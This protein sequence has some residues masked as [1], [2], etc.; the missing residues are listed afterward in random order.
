MIY[1]AW[2][3]YRQD[4]NEFFTYPPEIHRAIYTADAIE[5]LN[6][7]IK[8]GAKDRS[9]IVNDE[10]VYKIRYSAVRNSREKR[11]VLIK[12]RIVALNQFAVIFGKEWVQF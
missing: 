6:C 1:R 5:L 2:D 12:D 8:G 9:T 10:A 7:R 11:T 4:L 3:G